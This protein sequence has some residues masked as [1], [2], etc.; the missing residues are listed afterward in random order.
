MWHCVLG[1]SSTKNFDLES[2]IVS[3]I[4]WF[5]KDLVSCTHRISIFASSIQVVKFLYLYSANGVP[6]PP[7]LRLTMLYF[8][9]SFGGPSP[10]YPSD[11]SNL[12]LTRFVLTLHMLRY[13]GLY[14]EKYFG[15]Y[16]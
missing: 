5:V 10:G 14:A 16:L 13:R 15:W 8:T 7:I 9:T 4:L 12:S 3:A 11:E 1:A 6:A 2:V